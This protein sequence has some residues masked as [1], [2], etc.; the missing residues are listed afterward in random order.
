[1]NKKNDLH[2]LVFL[3]IDRE[4]GFMDIG[5]ATSLLL[6]MEEGGVKEYL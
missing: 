1:M 4:K 3:D 6:E 5:K 2:T